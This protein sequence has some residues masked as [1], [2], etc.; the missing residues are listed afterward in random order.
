ML[1]RSKTKLRYSSNCIKNEERVKAFGRPNPWRTR[2]Q[3]YLELFRRRKISLLYEHDKQKNI[4]PPRPFGQSEQVPRVSPQVS[5]EFQGAPILL[6][7]AQVTK[8]T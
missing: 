2:S 8:S 3:H 7:S 5:G 6:V 1:D 4:R